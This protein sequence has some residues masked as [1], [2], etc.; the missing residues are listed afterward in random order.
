MSLRKVQSLEDENL[1]LPEVEIRKEEE[2]KKKGKR[3][4]GH[5]VCVVWRWWSQ[6]I[7]KIKG[8]VGMDARSHCYKLNVWSPSHPRKFIC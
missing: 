8:N 7:F 3:L 5:K 1:Y 2:K 6:E 4:N